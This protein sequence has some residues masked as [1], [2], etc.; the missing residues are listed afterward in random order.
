M[1]PSIPVKN[2]KKL[3]GRYLK[4]DGQ[5]GLQRSPWGKHRVEKEET[6]EAGRAYGVAKSRQLIGS[7]ASQLKQTTNVSIFYSKYLNA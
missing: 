5:G 1:V 7:S 3:M 2:W 4:T 6:W